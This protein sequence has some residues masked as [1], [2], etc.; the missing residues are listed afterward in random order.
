MNKNKNAAMTSTKTTK[1]PT[2]DNKNADAGQQNCHG[3]KQCHGINKYDARCR[4]INN[5]NA[6]AMA[7]TKPCRSNKNNKN[8]P[9]ETWI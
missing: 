6:N 1:M 8:K 2:W 9:A 5:Y 3:R 7:S 4:S